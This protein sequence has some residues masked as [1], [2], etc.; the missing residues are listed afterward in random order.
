MGST[1]I[2]NSKSSVCISQSGS[3]SNFL[4]FLPTLLPTKQ[5]NNKLKLW[6][7]FQKRWIN[8]SIKFWVFCNKEFL[9]RRL[10]YITCFLFHFNYVIFINPSNRVVSE[11]SKSEM[12]YFSGILNQFA[13]WIIRGGQKKYLCLFDELT[14]KRL[15]YLSK[16]IIHVHFRIFFSSLIFIIHLLGTSQKA[17]IDSFC[18]YNLSTE[19]AC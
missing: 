11:D 12:I 7:K 18:W 3:Q 9:V 13:W 4:H 17:I 2:V 6:V 15:M 8:W 10:R 19:T 16:D 14:F 5:I 1:P